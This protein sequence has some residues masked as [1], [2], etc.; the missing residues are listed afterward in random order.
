MSG[1]STNSLRAAT[2]D[3]LRYVRA[4]NRS[5]ETIHAYR[6]TLLK[7]SAA[8][9]P[10]DLTRLTRRHVEA[11]MDGLCGGLAPASV[12]HHHKNLRAFLNWCVRDGRLRA[13]PMAGIPEPRVRP[14]VVEPFTPDQARALFATARTVRDRALVA[15]LLNTGVRISELCALRPEDI[16]AGRLRVMGKGAKQ[17]WVGV[18]PGTEREL[19]KLI[20]LQA[21]KPTVF[22][23]KRHAAYWA[24]RRLADRCGVPKTHPHRFRDT[25]AVRFLE[26]GGGVDN[27]QVLLGHSDIQTTLR[28]VQ[29]GREQR[30]I[31]SQVK[32]APSVC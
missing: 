2:R 29:Y 19:R 1:K 17:R 21:G 30:A 22:G 9:A 18:G 20:V 6:R 26:N 23:V 13:S 8:D 5:P 16:Q 28:Y 4:K 12:L 24:L 32:Y 10:G 11:W 31:E 3:Y 25:F 7:L 15:V 27:L 14:N